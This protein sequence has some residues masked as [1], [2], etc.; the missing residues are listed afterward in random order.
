MAERAQFH[1]HRTDQPDQVNEKE[2][3]L[4]R[5]T[6][7]NINRHLVKISPGNFY[8]Q[9]RSSLPLDNYTVAIPDIAVMEGSMEEHLPLKFCEAVLVIE[10]AFESLRHDRSI[11]RDMYAKAGIP[12]YWIVNLRNSTVEL[13][14]KPHPDTPRYIQEEILRRGDALSS[15]FGGANIPVNKLFLRA[16]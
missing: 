14:R 6:I 4:H 9:P 2:S 11:K 3:N 7:A 5:L 8:L 1:R 13:H 16:P 12:E 15:P 10:V